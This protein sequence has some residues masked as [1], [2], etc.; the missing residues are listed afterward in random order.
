MRSAESSGNEGYSRIVLGD[1][2]RRR[3]VPGDGPAPHRP[4]HGRKGHRPQDSQDGGPGI[5]AVF[6]VSFQTPIEGTSDDRLWI[7]IGDLPSAYLVMDA[8]GCVR[9]TL[10]SYCDLMTDWV[11]AVRTHSSLDDVFP[12]RADPTEEFAAMLDHRVKYLRQHII[13]TL[14]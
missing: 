5:V 13:E 12:V 9:E 4:R 8:G 3:R 7:V 11:T 1:L 6:I 2:A 10:Y 14:I